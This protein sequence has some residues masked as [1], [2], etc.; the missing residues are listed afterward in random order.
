M[1]FILGS[2]WK[3]QDWELFAQGRAHVLFKRSQSSSQFFDEYLLRLPK[4]RILSKSEVDAYFDTRENFWSPIIGRIHLLETFGASLTVSFVSALLAK[5]GCLRKSDVHMC[6]GL[7]VKNVISPVELKLKCPIVERPGT[8]TRIFMEQSLMNSSPY[9]P[10]EIFN[11][12][13][14]MIGIQKLISSRFHKAPIKPK[15]AESAILRIFENLE[16]SSLLVRLKCLMAFGVEE[17]AIRA[18][19]LQNLLNQVEKNNNVI[20]LAEVL[21]SYYNKGVDNFRD[22]GDLLLEQGCQPDSQINFHIQAEDWIRMFLLA[23]TAMDVSLLISNDEV[24]VIDLDV[25]PIQK[26][27]FYAEQFALALDAYQRSTLS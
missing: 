25:K 20:S 7:L 27:S 13:T 8:R 11:E 15:N 2:D 12:S 26:L 19:K 3:E 1:T 17:F 23:R 24:F 4:Q 10:A 22:T 18:L 14:R 6:Y 21:F 5:A 9:D 16:I